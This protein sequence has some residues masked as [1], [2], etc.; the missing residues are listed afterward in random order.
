MTEELTENPVEENWTEDNVVEETTTADSGEKIKLAYI[1]PSIPHFSLRN[2]MVLTGT[3]GE[4]E[5]FT[6]PLL[7][8][9]PE[10]KYL[11]VPVDKLS[12]AKRKMRRKGNILTKYYR[13]MAA[14]VK[15]NRRGKE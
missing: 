9:Y 15:A 14:K 10:I 13:D 8:R 4:I 3:E 1:G 7:E 11:L 2:A 12:D 5:A 6:K